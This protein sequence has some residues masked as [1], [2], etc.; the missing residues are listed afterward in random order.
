MW[1][2][3][4]CATLER[5]GP[6]SQRPHEI[7]ELVIQTQYLSRS[8]RPGFTGSDWTCENSSVLPCRFL[9][10]WSTRSSRNLPDFCSHTVAISAMLSAGELAP[11]ARPG[12][13]PQGVLR[14][15]EEDGCGLDGVL[16]RK[17]GEECITC[18]AP[19]FE[20]FRVET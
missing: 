6:T 17:R 11:G 14:A 20:G 16:P 12:G 2:T 5:L 9:L 13:G 3:H 1:A 15:S 19:C 4:S 10:P 8:V 18:R 7:L